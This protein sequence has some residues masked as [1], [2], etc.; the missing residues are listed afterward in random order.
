MKIFISIPM[1]SKSTTQVRVEMNKIF[2]FIKVK[3]PE[4][5]L[6]ESIIDDADKNIA[7]NGDDVAIWY[8]GKSIL[9]LSEA[10]IVFFINNY[11]DYRGCLIEKSIAEKYGKF[12][13]DL[14]INL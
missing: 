12:C 2:E 8:L 3:L 4:A 1:K 14:Q 9:L 7:L 13:V 10:D 11:K 6:I 5:E